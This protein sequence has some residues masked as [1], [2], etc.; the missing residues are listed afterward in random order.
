MK[1]GLEQL[2]AEKGMYDKDSQ[3]LIDSFSFTAQEID[4]IDSM[5]RTEGWKVMD[6]KIREE[7][8][9]RIKELVKD[10]KII[11]TLLALLVT[12]DTKSMS[13]N[14]DEEI[15]KLMPE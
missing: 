7:L 3:N 1:K 10:D 13:R 5:R 2:K 8:H 11:Q 14:L 6:K 15:S 12:A 4:K 9:I